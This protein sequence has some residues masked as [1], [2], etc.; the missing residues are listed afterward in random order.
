M[1]DSRAPF[2]NEISS[3]NNDDQA[4]DAKRKDDKVVKIPHTNSHT[5]FVIGDQQWKLRDEER[6]VRDCDLMVRLPHVIHPMARFYIHIESNIHDTRCI[7]ITSNW[8]RILHR[9]FKM[10]AKAHAWPTNQKFVRLI[11]DPGGHLPNS[12]SSSFQA[13]ENDAI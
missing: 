7:V 3:M 5:D 13:G 9:V 10:C 8:G 6:L 2:D 12:K 1:E 4:V 11:F